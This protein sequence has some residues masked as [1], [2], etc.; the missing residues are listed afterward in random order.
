MSGG[1]NEGEE[2]RGLLL[3]KSI[4]CCLGKVIGCCLGGEDE[5][6]EVRDEADNG[7]EDE[8]GVDGDAAAVLEEE[9]KAWV[10]LALS[11]CAICCLS[12]MLEIMVF[13][14]RKDRLGR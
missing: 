1:Q 12:E 2:L 7:R 14:S 13:I 11:S 8:R 6:E 10:P 3:S 5:A 4:G 9:N